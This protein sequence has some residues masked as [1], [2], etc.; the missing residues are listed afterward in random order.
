M[1]YETIRVGQLICDS[2]TPPE[3]RGFYKIDEK[4]T[5]V[6]GDLVFVHPVSGK[7][8][9]PVQAVTSPGG[10]IT[11]SAGNAVLAGFVPADIALIGDSRTLGT[12]LDWSVSVV[13]PSG[14]P[15]SGQYAQLLGA[16]AGAALNETGLYEYDH[17]TGKHRWTCGADVPGPWQRAVVGRHLLESGSPGRGLRMMLWRPHTANISDAVTLAGARTHHWR[18]YFLNRGGLLDDIESEFW[19]ATVKMLGAGGGHTRD[20]VTL[21]PYFEREA[22]G[23][24]V[25][26]WWCGTNDINN[27]R[28]AADII[29]FAQTVLDAR[30]ALGR[31]IVIIGEHAR[32]GVDTSTPID[33]GKRAIHAAYNAWLRE[34]AAAHPGATVFIDALALTRDVAQTDLRPQ[35][36]VP[37]AFDMVYDTVHPWLGTKLL[38]HPLVIAAIRQ[39]IG[40]AWQRSVSAKGADMIDFIGQA[41]WPGTDGTV[42][43]PTT[44]TTGTPTG[45]TANQAANV[46]SSYNKTGFRSEPGVAVEC[47]YSSTPGASQYTR[48]YTVAQTLIALGLS[49]GEWLQFECLCEVDSA[50]INDRIEIYATFNGSSIRASMQA[51]CAPGV[52]RMKTQ[53]LQIPPGSTSINFRLEVWT[54]TAAASSGKLRFGKFLARK[55]AAPPTF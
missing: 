53:P 17:A 11:A 32:W 29:A 15:R 51:P 8:S 4:T 18:S 47:V 20:M 12:Y 19:G 28:P 24:G 42:T 55:V 9:V 38:L 22:G 44:T 35:A 2:T 31:R 16:Q 50:G 27:D 3:D 25:D 48:I 34:Y 1:S 13:S 49:V 7:E 26:V 21:L 33:A 40:P 37:G 36:G 6:V 30:L 10:G 23:A 45:T 46:T 39:F 41:W 52:Y 43:A 5:G 54:D 14:V